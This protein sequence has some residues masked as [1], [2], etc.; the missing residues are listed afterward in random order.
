MRLKESKLI[1]GELKVSNWLFIVVGV[2]MTI[3]IPYILLILE[4]YNI[5]S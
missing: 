4:H 1:L 5:F 2:L 3:S